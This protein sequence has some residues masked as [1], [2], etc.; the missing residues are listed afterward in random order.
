[1]IHKFT[2]LGLLTAAATLGTTLTGTQSAQA[3]VLTYQ[4]EV[5]LTESL[6]LTGAPEIRFP[7]NLDFYVG[8]IK[9]NSHLLT[10]VGAETLGV[11]DGLE[12]VL[13]SDPRVNSKDTF[14]PTPTIANFLDGEFVGVNWYAV[15]HP[16]TNIP[17]QG[18]LGDFLRIEGDSFT[19]GFDTTFYT[20]EDEPRA[21][22]FGFGTVEYTPVPEPGSLLCLSLIVVGGGLRRKLRARKAS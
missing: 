14:S 13:A 12:V 5:E 16:F 17:E 22:T 21:P 2:Q 19:D 6:F 20:P 18:Y 10:G 9:I 11:S 4:F 15:Y 8:T 1:M 3:R 7:A